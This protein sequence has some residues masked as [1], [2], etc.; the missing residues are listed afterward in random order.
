MDLDLARAEYTDMGHLTSRTFTSRRG[1]EGA[2]DRS[3]EVLTSDCIPDV[4]DLGVY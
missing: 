1:L 3:M 4:A 2:A